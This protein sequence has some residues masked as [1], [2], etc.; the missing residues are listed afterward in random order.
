MFTLCS[1]ASLPLCV[2]ACVLWVRSWSRQ[3][4]IQY[5]TRTWLLPVETR[6]GSTGFVLWKTP[7]ESPG[8]VHATEAPNSREW[9]P[10]IGLCVALWGGNAVGDGFAYSSHAPLY[11]VIMPTRA[12]PLIAGMLPMVWVVCAT[13]KV[14]R[15]RRRQRRRGLGLC[16][17]CGYDVRAS[18]GRCPEC[19]TPTK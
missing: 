7:S 3:E 17:G 6:F 14:L 2:A 15:H 1:A 13:G 4:V 5:Q 18:P 9:P 8:F 12:V 10:L 11:A 16:P 19:G